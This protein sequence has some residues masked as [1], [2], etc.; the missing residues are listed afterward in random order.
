[1][2]KLLYTT[3]PEVRSA[4]DDDARKSVPCVLYAFIVVVVIVLIVALGSVL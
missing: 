1:M 4:Y 2:K 3:R